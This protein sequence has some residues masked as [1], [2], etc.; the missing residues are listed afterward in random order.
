MNFL[1]IWLI[2]ISVV[3]AKHLILSASEAEEASSANQESLCD[4]DLSAPRVLW[5]SSNQDLI[6]KENEV[7]SQRFLW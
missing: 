7:C 1:L 4:V 2:P 3:S 6:F 5:D